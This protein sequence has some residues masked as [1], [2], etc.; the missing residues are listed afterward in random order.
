MNT[1]ERLDHHRVPQK[2]LSP[3]TCEV[4]SRSMSTQSC[5]HQDPVH[6]LSVPRQ[7]THIVAEQFSSSMFNKASGRDGSAAVLQVA[8]QPPA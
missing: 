1:C 2:M 7:Q 8:R 4:C 6:I 5:E 3:D